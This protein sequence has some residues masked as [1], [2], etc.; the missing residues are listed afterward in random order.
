[1]C[2][3]G[4]R[5]PSGHAREPQGPIAHGLDR[6]DAILVTIAVATLG[7]RKLQERGGRWLKLVSGVVMLA[8]GTLLLLRPTW[9]GFG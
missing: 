8:L 6:R 4:A 9:L 1:L 3:L 7:K 5:V 2:N